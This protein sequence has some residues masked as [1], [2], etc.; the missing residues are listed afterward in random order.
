MHEYLKIRTATYIKIYVVEL[1]HFLIIKSIPILHKLY[2]WS[3]LTPLYR[4]L[5]IYR[6]ISRLLIKNFIILKYQ[7]E[8][9]RFL[10]ALPINESESF[11]K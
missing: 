3:G 7:E 10:P 6:S 4:Y 11:K 9:F 8:E 2:Y 1:K 5:I